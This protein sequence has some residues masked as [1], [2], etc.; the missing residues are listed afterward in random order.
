[1]EGPEDQRY[2][3]R[4]FYTIKERGEFTKVWVIRPEDM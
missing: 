4:L 2:L 3:V 1:M